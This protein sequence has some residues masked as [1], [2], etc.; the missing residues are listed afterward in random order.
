MQLHAL[1]G[2]FYATP[3]KKNFGFDIFNANSTGAV[4]T[5]EEKADSVSFKECIADIAVNQKQ[6]EATVSFYFICL[7]H[8]ANEKT[9]HIDDQTDLADLTISKG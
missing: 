5:N 8:L 9:L 7:L 6:K 4:L 1:V 3:E 2:T